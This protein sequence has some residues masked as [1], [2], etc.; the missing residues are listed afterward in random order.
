M[1]ANKELRQLEDDALQ[2]EFWLTLRHFPSEVRKAPF[3]A[4]RVND[5]ALVCAEIAKSHA[6]SEVEN[7]FEEVKDGIRGKHTISKG[8]WGVIDEVLSRRRSKG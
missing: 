2:H 8:A 7:A 3:N 6:Q 1:T 5:Y 4:R